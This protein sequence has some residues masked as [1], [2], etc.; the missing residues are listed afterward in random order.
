MRFL[1]LFAFS[2]L[3]LAPSIHS[4]PAPVPR[5]TRNVVVRQDD[6][7]FSGPQTVH[8]VNTANT[9]AGTVTTTCDIT[10]TPVQ[11]P[12]GES[13]VREDQ[14]CQISV[15]GQDTTSTTSTSTSNNG[16]T[17]NTG[18]TSS[19][20]SS[21]T[22]SDNGTDTGAGTSTSS[23][24]NS[25]T[26]STTSS[27]TTS[28]TTGTT[29]S[30]SGDGVTEDGPIVGEAPISAATA[31]TDVAGAAPTSGSAA[32]SSSVAGALAS[33]VSAAS[34]AVSPSSSGTSAN[35]TAASATSSA[36]V[37]PGKTLSVLPI[38][39]GV[40]AGISVIALIVVGLV[41][42]ERTKYR[43][44]FRQRRLAEQGANM[45]YGGAMQQA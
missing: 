6:G 28:A 2:L 10:L 16:G 4:L 42:Y 21:T 7:T 23:D 20:G 29:S 15:N 30:S 37:I 43:R 38:G 14:N 32:A 26:N 11:G 39:L 18:T 12:N 27:T 25:G 44:A 5:W 8:T 40:F 35:D 24:T 22:S 19:D 13:L 31:A 34:S 36:F 3:S 45:G 9:A 33:A 17:S 1:R 41:T